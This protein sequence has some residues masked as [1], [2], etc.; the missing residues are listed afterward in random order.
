ML[1]GSNCLTERGERLTNVAVREVSAKKLL[2][3]DAG[4]E[5]ARGVTDQRPPEACGGRLRDA[6]GPIDGLRVS[7]AQDDR[8]CSLRA[9]Q[10]GRG[11]VKLLRVARSPLGARAWALGRSAY[12]SNCSTPSSE[13]RVTTMLPFVVESCG[14]ASITL[15]SHS[16]GA[17]SSLYGGSSA[18]WRG[19]QSGGLPRRV[20]ARRSQGERPEDRHVLLQREGPGVTC[21]ADNLRRRENA[22]RQRA[23]ILL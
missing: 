11:G 10:Q 16:G 1:P 2:T 18:P 12:C 14:F 19:S 7:P 9:T 6:E 5:V 3:F 15:D 13:P 22:L 23:R 4:G 8:R 21:G 17:F 20:R